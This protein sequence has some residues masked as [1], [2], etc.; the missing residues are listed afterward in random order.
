MLIRWITSKSIVTDL[1]ILFLAIISSFNN[2]H[3]LLFSRT[4]KEPPDN[5]S[6][7]VTPILNHPVNM[8]SN[9]ER[10]LTGWVPELN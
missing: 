6:K 1:D 4:A 9:A 5:T 7:G 8:I 3:F 10:I 2:N